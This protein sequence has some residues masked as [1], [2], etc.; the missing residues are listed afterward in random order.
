[1]Q[2]FL[3]HTLITDGDENKSIFYS[4]KCIKDSGHSQS[5]VAKNY[6]TKTKIFSDSSIRFLMNNIESSYRDCKISCLLQ[7]IDF[8][9]CM[10]S[11][12][13]CNPD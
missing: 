11:F 13:L 2:K 5:Y 3:L 6:V 9:V 1:M 8:L 7:L 12:N 4:T 10:I